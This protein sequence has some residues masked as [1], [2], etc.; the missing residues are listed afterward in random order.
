MSRHLQGA[1]TK[2]YFKTYSNN[3]QWARIIHHYSTPRCH[4]KLTQQYYSIK[5]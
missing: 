3:V 5:C 2:V 4:M 1:D